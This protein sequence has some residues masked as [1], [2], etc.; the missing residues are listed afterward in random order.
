LNGTVAL[1]SPSDLHWQK[2]GRQKSALCE[3]VW[4]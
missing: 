3:G 2:A 4:T 1:D